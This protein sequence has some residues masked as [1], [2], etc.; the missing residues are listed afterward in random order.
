MYEKR[1]LRAALYSRA[2][3]V[4]TNDAS[5]EVGPTEVVRDDFSA[6]VKRAMARN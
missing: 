4:C 2:E 6:R 3:A 1:L 5:M